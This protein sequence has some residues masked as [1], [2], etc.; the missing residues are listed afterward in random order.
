[1]IWLP[2]VGK[3]ADIDVY[4]SIMAYTD[5]LNQRG[6]CA[7]AYIPLS[8][9]NYSIP[10]SLRIKRYEDGVFDLQPSD[11]VIILDVSVPDAINKLVPEHQILELIDHHP[12]YE[13]YWEKRLG[14]KAIIEPIGAVAT[15]ITE[16][17]GEC[18]NYEK[19]PVDI[20]KL[21]LAAILDNTLNFNA[22]ITT[23][24]DHAAARILA[25]VAST[26]VEQ[27]ANWYF[28]EVSSKILDDLEGSLL[29]DCKMVDLEKEERRIDFGQLTIW[30]V[31]ELL[32]QCVR[33]ANV[34]TRRNRDWV[35]NIIC[36][37]ECKNYILTSS[38]NWKRYFMN[39]LDAEKCG[40][41]L[42]TDR[43]FL[44]KEIIGK[45]LA[46]KQ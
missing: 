21:L 4:A 8:T 46:R 40:D 33:I 36:L 10:E 22:T 45:M 35:V 13:E 3:Y 17:W 31:R 24:R 39:L 27:F 19:M 14:D 34:M 32:P 15:S 37:S 18:W 20:A 9:L 11:E 6:K 12:G 7:R 41:W 1:M 38:E 29:L 5:L 2:V 25:D 23:K 30:D 44:R 43:L 26:S 16:W 42:V 28:S